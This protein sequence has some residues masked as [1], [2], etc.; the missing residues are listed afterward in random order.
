MRAECFFSLTVF[1]GSQPS[2]MASRSRRVWEVRDASCSN[3]CKPEVIVIMLSL[4]CSSR[5]LQSRGIS[6]SNLFQHLW[7]PQNVI[8]R[9]PKHRLGAECDV[10]QR[11]RI[12][13]LDNCR[14][15][16]ETAKAAEQAE[17]SETS[18]TFVMKMPLAA[19]LKTRGSG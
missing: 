9:L 4:C 17:P 18:H 3:W 11:T 13:N 1:P 2:Q 10:F 8:Q 15:T 16:W 6:P 14:N 7:P 19:P 12:I 5:A